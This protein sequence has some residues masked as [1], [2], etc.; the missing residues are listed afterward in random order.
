MVT[1]LSLG[2]YVRFLGRRSGT[3]VMNYMALSEVFV[4]PSWNEA[5]G[6]VYIEAMAQGKPV[7]G[8]RGEGIEDFVTDGVNGIL[9]PPRNSRE[10]A[11]ALAHLLA[12]REK[13]EEIGSR[14]K[15]TVMAR[16]TWFQVARELES[17][18]RR[19]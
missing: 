6:V 2:A 7:I 10:L 13:A 12:Y 8:C 5:F 15:E 16:Y 19:L 9:V 1:D 11:R 14:G 3:E 18:Y 17:L 4:L